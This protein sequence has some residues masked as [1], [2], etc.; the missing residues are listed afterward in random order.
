MRRK[1]HHR[2]ALRTALATLSL[3]AVAACDRA[4]APAEPATAAAE[5]A[6]RTVRLAQPRRVL[7]VV[8]RWPAESLA[9]AAHEA[10]LA[11]PVAG[12][13]TAVLVA[14]G[15]RVAAG[16]ALLRMRSPERSAAAASERA[17]RLQLEV[18]KRRL[19]QVTR[20]QAQGLALA[21]AR[22]ALE[23]DAASLQAEIAR[24]RA[25]LAATAPVGCSGAQGG[26][27]ASELTL[28]APMAGVVAEVHARLG[29]MLDPSD[30]AL[31]R[32]RAE[33]PGRVRLRRFGAAP[34]GATLRFVA[35]DR[36]VTLAEQP[37]SALIDEATGAVAAVHL[38]EPATTLAAGLRGEVQA[39]LASGA[40][41][42]ARAVYAVPRA[43]VAQRGGALVVTRV[44]ADGAAEAVPVQIVGGDASET[45]LRAADGATLRD[46][47]AIFA[48]APGLA[49][50]GEE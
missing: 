35:T 47:D 38:P 22:F 33:G 32:L 40:A 45:W 39:T 4:D 10:V 25:T 23:R 50:G 11:T 12:L 6:S 14:P 42:G 49:G 20:Q 8:A 5:V 37:L 28:C 24:A 36:Q 29:A 21:D 27:D 34:R 16:A 48:V 44:G 3:L 43:A 41:D 30:E 9:T 18:V 26:D 13:C 17:A 2:V 31:V 15:D 1:G 19:A 7:G 46:G